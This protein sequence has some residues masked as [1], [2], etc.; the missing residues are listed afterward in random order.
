MHYWWRLSICEGG[1]C[2]P[3]KFEFPRFYAD[4][5][6]A[7]EYVI[8]FTNFF[9]QTVTDTIQLKENI[10]DYQVCLDD[11]Q[12][13]ESYPLLDA[14]HKA[15]TIRI[16]QRSIGCYHRSSEELIFK[17]HGDLLTV[18]YSH[19]GD[20]KKAKIDTQ[21]KLTALYDFFS[22]ADLMNERGGCTTTDYYTLNFD[23]QEITI[24]DGGCSWRGFMQLVKVLF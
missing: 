21:P 15:K 10:T 5:L 13:R 24:E 20:Y 23:E 9:N 16:R 11:F 8:K 19:N 6:K 18:K 2:N 22:K 17:K 1:D 4:S 12:K 7:G 3:V 14:F